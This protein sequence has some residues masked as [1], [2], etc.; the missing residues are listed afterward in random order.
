LA[1]DEETFYAAGGGEV[2]EEIRELRKPKE[3]K[4]R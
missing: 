3:K 1:P 2:E 4:G